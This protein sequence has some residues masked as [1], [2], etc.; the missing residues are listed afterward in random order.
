M[1]TNTQKKGIVLFNPVTTK[2]KVFAT[3]AEA[4]KWL[5]VDKSTVS[6]AVSGDRNIRGVKGYIAVPVS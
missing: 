1:K 2:A 6:R 5:S 4:A 3:I